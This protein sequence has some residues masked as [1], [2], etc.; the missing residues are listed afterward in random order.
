MNLPKSPKENQRYETTIH[1]RANKKMDV[2]FHL[3][4]EKFTYIPRKILKK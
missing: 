1:K 2:Q 4:S 3:Q